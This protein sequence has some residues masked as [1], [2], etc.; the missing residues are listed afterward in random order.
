MAK[1][2]NDGNCNSKH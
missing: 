1:V 2:M